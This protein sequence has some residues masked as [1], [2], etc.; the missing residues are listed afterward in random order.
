MFSLLRVSL[1][2][3]RKSGSGGVGRIGSKGTENCSHDLIY[4]KNKN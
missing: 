3:Q 4:I 1:G 2:K